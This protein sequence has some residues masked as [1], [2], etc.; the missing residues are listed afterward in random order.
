MKKK[1][2]QRKKKHSCKL[3][4]LLQNIK[5]YYSMVKFTNELNSNLLYFFISFS[6]KLFRFI[7]H[8][9]YLSVCLTFSFFI[10][11]FVKL[12]FITI[13]HFPQRNQ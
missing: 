7:S 2:K 6:Y 5:S 9:W 10:N 1:K 8:I 4:Y 12:H 3:N 13:R 11:I